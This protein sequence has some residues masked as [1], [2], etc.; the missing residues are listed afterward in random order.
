[1]NE[2]STPDCLIESQSTS[3]SLFLNV[4]SPSIVTVNENLEHK[5]AINL[6]VVPELPTFKNPSGLE[7]PF[8]PTP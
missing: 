2:T 4:S 5:S 6:R 7:K 3:V 8:F 1:M